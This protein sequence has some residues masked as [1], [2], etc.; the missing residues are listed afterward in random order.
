MLLKSPT[1]I[2][3]RPNCA[4]QSHKATGSRTS[5][6]DYRALTYLAHLTNTFP[7]FHYSQAASFCELAF[8]GFLVF[9]ILKQG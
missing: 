2:A 4:S 7:Q 6:H 1:C 8:A 9:W 5:S 3:H